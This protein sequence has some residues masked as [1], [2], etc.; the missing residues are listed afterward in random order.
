MRA[1]QHFVLHLNKQ[2]L[3]IARAYWCAARPR[4]SKSS[5]GRHSA[6]AAR[7]PGKLARGCHQ[8]QRSGFNS[9]SSTVSPEQARPFFDYFSWESFIA[10]NWPA[11]GS[12][13]GTPDQPNNAS[14]FLNAP[15]GTAIVWGTYKDSFDLFGQKTQR[16]NAW[17]APSGPVLPCANAQAGQK[18][19]IFVTKGDTPVMQTTQAFS[20]PLIDQRSN[21]VYYDIR[22]DQA[23]YSFIRG[24]DSDPTSWLYLLKNLA[25]KENTPAGLQM[26][27][28]TS[29]PANTLGSI[30]IKAAWRIQTDKDD[31]RRFYATKA[32]VLNPQTQQCTETPILLVG[33]HIGHKIAPFT[34][35]VW[36]T[37]EQ[38]DNVP[39]DGDVTPKPAPPPNGYSF[40]NGTDVPKTTGGYNYKPQLPSSQ[41][42]PLVPVQVVRVNPIPN[43]PSGASTRDVNAFYQQLLKGTV[44]QYYQ[45][46]ITQWPS[47]PGLNNFVLMQNG[48]VYPRD[49]EAA[50]PATGAV[51]TTQETYFQIQSDAAGAGGN[52]CMSCHYRAGQSDF[53]WG[54]NRRAY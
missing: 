1:T 50:F 19:L 20:A 48:G 7:L 37:F 24:Q 46:V 49:A 42:T 34:A 21:Y 3:P 9:G 54:L 22:Y 33:F 38:I 5:A 15:N 13:R 30:M 31:P 41:P 39:V 28:S 52:S 53:S 14:I 18:M 40:N 16:P 36:S 26:P 32:L 47:N 44:W 29:T 6:L 25:P 23:E 10:L 4:F 17:D 11:A 12:P 27:M 45:L 35:W 51:N 43:T 8:W 2:Q